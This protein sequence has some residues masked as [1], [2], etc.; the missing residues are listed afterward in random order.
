MTIHNPHFDNSQ[1]IVTCIIGFSHLPIMYLCY[2]VT[3][4]GQD[5]QVKNGPVDVKHGE[6]GQSRVFP[7]VWRGQDQSRLKE[8]LKSVPPQ[9]FQRGR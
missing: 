2:K 5:N 4:F 1:P 6:K 3:S 7:L 9:F 8:C